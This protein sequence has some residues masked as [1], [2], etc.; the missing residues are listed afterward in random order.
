MDCRVAALEMTQFLPINCLT[1]E[2]NSETSIMS[3]RMRSEMLSVMSDLIKNAGLQSKKS[4]LLFVLQ[5]FQIILL[6]GVRIN[7][8]VFEMFG[9]KA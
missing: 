8:N 1:S 3:H 2:R 7:P 4:A 6:H 9:I 5:Q